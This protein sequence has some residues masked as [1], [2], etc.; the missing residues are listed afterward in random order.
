[1]SRQSFATVLIGKN[2]LVREGIARI[3]RAEHF[4]ILASVSSID[5]LPSTLQSLQLLFLIVQAGDDFDLVVEHIRLVRDQH[6]G[7]RI[8]IVANHDRPAEMASAFRA[9]ASGYFVNV[10][11]CDA[12]IK[13]IELVAMGET[14]F[15]PAFLS[16]ALDTKSDHGSKAAPPDENERAIFVTT[17]DTIAPQ[18]SPREKSILRCL[19][20]GDSNKGIAR[21]ID[22]ADAT[23]KVHVKAILRKIRVQNRT[24]AAIW[25]L[26]HGTLAVAQKRSAPPSGLDTN[27]PMPKAIDVISN[28]KRLETS[29]S[30]ELMNGQGNHVAVPRTASLFPKPRSKDVSRLT[31]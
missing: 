6:P 16:F 11:S 24:Q 26:N 10:N 13:S 7:G 14:V 8:A 21:K 17:E 31:N 30:R 28:V 15:P 2:I 19:I 23:V 20:E 22:I 3:L 4:Q 29:G 12:F 1:M 5:E 9:G 25:A 27:R 18:L